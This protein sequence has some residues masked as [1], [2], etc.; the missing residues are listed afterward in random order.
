MT[1]KTRRDQEREATRRKFLDA[2]RELFV[3]EGFESTSMR[4]IA[5]KTGYSPTAIYSHFEDKEALLYELCD[6]DFRA[7]RGSFERI[8]RIADAVDR[9]RAL[10]AA[11]IEFVLAHPNQYRLMFMTPHPKAC[12]ENS[13]IEHGNPDQDA[14]AFL[15][16]TVAEAMAAGRFRA[17]FDDADLVA[18][19]VWS[20][21]HGLAALH[22]TK[23]N[24]GWIEFRPLQST[25]KHV[26]E[27]MIRGLIR[28]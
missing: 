4:K 22:L 1:P 10:G 9:L 2:A 21:V 13:T 7:L 20:G 28:E 23:G 15:K 16:A 17:E 14:Y 12:P 8:A 27:V 26:I 5:E 11:Y 18:Q 24:D 19:I 25:A 6:V 3:S